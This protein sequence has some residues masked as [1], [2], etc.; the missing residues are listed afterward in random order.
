ML[1]SPADNEQ[2]AVACFGGS[3][4]TKLLLRDTESRINYLKVGR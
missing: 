2:Q 1:I 4:Q 3:F